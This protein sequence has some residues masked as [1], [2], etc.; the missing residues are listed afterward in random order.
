[1]R[2]IGETQRYGVPLVL[3]VSYTPYQ[4]GAFSGLCDRCGSR[5]ERGRWM[6]W[7]LALLPMIVAFIVGGV[8][9]KGALGLVGLVLGVL[10]MRGVFYSWIDGM[11]W[12]QG[13]INQLGLPPGEKYTLPASVLSVLMRALIGPIAFVFILTSVLAAILG[14]RP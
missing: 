10:A 7:V 2:Q 14:V 6:A 4:D 12:G 5:I 9:D 11:V 1:M 3:T 13:V 8:L